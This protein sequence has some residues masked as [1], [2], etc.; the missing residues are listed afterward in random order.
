MTESRKKSSDKKSR[1]AVSP[2]LERVARAGYATKGVIY[3]IIGLLATLAAFNAGGETTDSRGAFQK[4]LE[5]P[6]GK[7][8]LGIVAVGLAGYAIWRVTQGI[9]DAE[10]KGKDTKGISI[11]IAYAISGI[12]HSSLALSAGYLVLGRAS[13]GGDAAKD[14]TAQLLQL[15]LGPWLVGLAGLGII[16]FGLYQ[17]Y[18]GYKTKFRKRLK[19]S[20]MSDTGQTWAMRSGQIGLA[21][22][23]IV[24]T[25]MGI[26]LIRAAMQSN[27]G[28]AR[29][30]DGALQALVQQPFGKLVM[31]VV[32]MGLVA[33]GF[34]MFV[35]AKYHRIRAQ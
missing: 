31:G 34:Y 32:A 13:G 3:I 30:L 8:L 5:Q 10:G 25:V 18:K 19:V 17:I 11:R 29:G 9:I 7:I 14:R 1:A 15:P 27:P 23:G 35:E 24:F 28:E 6:Y 12:I 33:Y 22:R 4:I 21:A 2:W 26:F 20:A 16:C